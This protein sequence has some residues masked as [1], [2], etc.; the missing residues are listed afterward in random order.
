MQDNYTQKAVKRLG[1]EALLSKIKALVQEERKLTLSILHHLREVERRR[2]F[3]ALAYPSLF[4]YAVRE[5]GYSPSAAQ[6]R[7][8]AMRLLRELPEMEAKIQ[9]GKL[10]LPVVAQAQS[11]F[12]QEAKAA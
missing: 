2:L 6:R 10:S 1:D 12:H 8:S 4:E 5:L 11:F 3:A 9:E 7:I